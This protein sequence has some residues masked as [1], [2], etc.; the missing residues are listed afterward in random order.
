MDTGYRTGRHAIGDT[1]THIGH[2]GMRHGQ[3]GYTFSFR[4]TVE[5]S[6]LQ[7]GEDVNP[8]FGE[9]SRGKGKT[10]LTSTH[11]APE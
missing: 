11:P 1:F 8:L 2:N 10:V 6:R 9:K 3:D 5:I 4:I 7:A